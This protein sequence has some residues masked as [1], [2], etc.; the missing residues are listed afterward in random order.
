M[1]GKLRELSRYKGVLVVASVLLGLFFL[2]TCIEHIGHDHERPG[3]C[4]V[5]HL[6][7]FPGLPGFEAFSVA[8]P[9]LAVGTFSPLPWAGA[10]S[11]ASLQIACR[12]PPIPFLL[13]A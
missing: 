2:S 1:A 4:T 10:S 3:H 8:P 5:C 9:C 7:S 13:S 11:G 12:A 6:A